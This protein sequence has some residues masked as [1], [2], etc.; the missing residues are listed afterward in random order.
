[1]SAE[2]DDRP[3]RREFLGWLVRGAALAGLAAAGWAMV[4]KGSAGGGADPE[5]V[6]RG[7]CRGC[8]VLA[9]CRLPR[10]RTAKRRPA[11]R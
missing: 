8:P 3:S 11:K 9:S 5:C 6:N 1:M 2:K 7:R 4:F 10:A